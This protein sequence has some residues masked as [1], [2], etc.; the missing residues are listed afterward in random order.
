MLPGQSTF[1]GA[2]CPTGA[3][4]GGPTPKARHHFRATAAGT[5]RRCRSTQPSPA[6][7]LAATRSAEQSV[8]ASRSTVR[9]TMRAIGHGSRSHATQSRLRQ[10]V[11]RR[12]RAGSRRVEG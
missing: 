4:Q 12:A 11:R 6:S 8:R 5:V 10:V 1:R 3:E 9:V 7:A 2:C